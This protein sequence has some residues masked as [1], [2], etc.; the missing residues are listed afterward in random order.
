MD[1]A[2]A[3]PVP[4]KY[5]LQSLLSTGLG[6]SFP[7]AV[8]TSYEK[9]EV[10][11]PEIALAELGTIRI[12]VDEADALALI[13]SATVKAHRPVNE[14]PGSPSES[15]NIPGIWE[16][17]ADKVSVSNSVFLDWLQDVGGPESLDCIGASEQSGRVQYVLKGLVIHEASQ[18]AFSFVPSTSLLLTKQKRLA[19][20]TIQT[21][22]NKLGE[23]VVILP[24]SYTDGNITHAHLD[25]DFPLDLTQDCN[26]RKQTF[27]VISA[28]AGVVEIVSPVTT[29]FRV[30]L[31]YDILHDG[32]WLLPSLLSPKQRLI[33][34]LSPWASQVVSTWSYPHGVLGCLLKHS[35]THSAAFD[36]SSLAGTSDELLF[37]L[38]CIVAR[39]LG[40]HIFFG[41]IELLVRSE[42]A[43][44][45]NRQF[46][47]SE[48]EKAS[49]AT[50]FDVNGIPVAVEELEQGLIQQE[51]LVIQDGIQLEPAISVTYSA[52]KTHIFSMYR[53]TGLLLWPHS[54]KGLSVKAADKIV[55]YAQEVLE[56]SQ[57]MTPSRK[58]KV[59]FNALLGW[60]K[61]QDSDAVV[62]PARLLQKCSRQWWDPE[63]FFRAALACG[64][65]KSIAVL[66][67]EGYVS[68]YLEF[69]WL[70][71]IRNLCEAALINDNSKLRKWCLIVCLWEKAM[72]Y[73]DLQLEAW[74]EG[75]QSR[76]LSSLAE[77]QP[78]D[79]P[80]LMSL[81]MSGGGKYLRNVIYPH[82]VS[83]WL[84]I[85]AFWIPFMRGLHEHRARIPYLEDPKAVYDVI[86]LA[87]QHVTACLSPFPTKFVGDEEVQDVNI[88]AELMCCCLEIDHGTSICVAL[89]SK[90]HDAAARGEWPK[91]S[92]WPYYDVM[93]DIIRKHYAG[94]PCQSCAD[95]HG[96][97][98]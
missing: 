39:E 58:E 86:E 13:S 55:E 23:L 83:Q 11:D 12:P 66:G 31:L 51:N 34:L 41:Q 71:S 79:I 16:I 32:S 56:D 5:G 72:L 19:R 82:L 78:S 18:Y 10:P 81:C 27:S 52:E 60:C 87:I 7:L 84:P 25:E 69:G 37:K 47:D 88:V 17:P 46:W 20:R 68:A 49:I 94:E 21:S 4:I 1:L 8:G 98:L 95:S 92:P 45:L 90:M 2:S 85:E 9:E 73:G 63:L 50:I 80:W 96:N 30:S 3:S 57:T 28:H 93:V 53:H 38:F 74:C 65:D 6:R 43:R 40:F 15:L 89:T 67:P 61:S 44:E 14:T 54:T 35:Y 59:L 91:P 70:N 24:C 75:H 22:S 33:R 77:L 76:L 62:L 26:R 64:C 36:S 42:V 29:G 48:I 97:F